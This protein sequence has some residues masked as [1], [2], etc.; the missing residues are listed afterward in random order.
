MNEI[1]SQDLRKR[2]A[3]EKLFILDVRTSLEFTTFNIGG[4]NIPVQ[5]LNA[6]ADELEEL[7]S[8]EIIVVCQH[9]IRS[10]TAQAILQAGG[11]K[12]VKNLLGGLVNFNRIV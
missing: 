8:T 5:Q 11:F 9:G 7:K 1:S 6:N 12:N 2:L 4:L 10:V 3:N